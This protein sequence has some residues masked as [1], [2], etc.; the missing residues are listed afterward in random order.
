MARYRHPHGSHSS[1]KAEGRMKSGHRPVFH[2]RESQPN[3][4]Y[5]SKGY[6]TDKKPSYYVKGREVKEYKHPTA[7]QE[8]EVRRSK[9]NKEEPKEKKGSYR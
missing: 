7:A 6:W 4:V 9:F 2:V 5:G 3:S 8:R 1:S